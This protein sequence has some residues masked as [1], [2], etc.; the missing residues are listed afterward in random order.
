MIF[1]S[2]QKKDDELRAEEEKAQALKKKGKGVKKDISKKGKKS[3]GKKW[4]D[5]SKN[6]MSI[7]S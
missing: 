2:K 6:A 4:W 5:L 7:V 1:R 3:K